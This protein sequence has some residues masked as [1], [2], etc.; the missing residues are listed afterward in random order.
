MRGA[1]IFSPPSAAILGRYYHQGSEDARRFLIDR[2]YL[3]PEVSNEDGD[4]SMANSNNNNTVPFART[5]TF[6][7]NTHS[8][9]GEDLDSQRSS[10]SPK[11]I[12]RLVQSF[13]NM[14][15]KFKNRESSVDAPRAPEKETP[16]D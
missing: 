9:N 7:N 6:S 15:R 3:D 10:R 5:T 16:V 2:G 14:T 13:N 11:I 4:G 8:P 1:H 12:S